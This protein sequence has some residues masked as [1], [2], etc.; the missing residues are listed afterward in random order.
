MKREIIIAPSILSLDYSKTDEQLENV[1]NSEAKWL[2]FDVMDGHFVPNLTFGPDILR[3]FKKKTSMFMDVHIMVSD[4]VFISEI[5]INQGADLVTFHY[6]ALGSIE[7]CIELCD[8]IHKFGCKCGISIKPDTK[9]EVL[10]PILDSI[11]LVLVMSVTPG[12]G[13]QSFIE[14]SL[15]KIKYLD[16]YRI[17][18]TLPYLIEVDGGIN[19]ETA[20]LCVEAGVDVLVAGSYIF[21]HNIEEKVKELKCLK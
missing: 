11:D 12:F 15:D 10:E 8:K 4:P 3:G 20:N 21:K 18:N 19:F 17:Q 5:F 13:G 6:E 14:S 1:M 9:V 7:K 16:A 2:H